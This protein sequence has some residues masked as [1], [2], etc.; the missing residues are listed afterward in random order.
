MTIFFNLLL[1]GNKQ[2]KCCVHA[3][4]KQFK[5]LKFMKIQVLIF[6]FLTSSLF[7]QTYDQLAVQ[8][9]NDMII[10]NELQATPNAPETWNF[11]TW[12]NSN[13]KQIERLSLNHRN[14][15]GEVSFAGLNNLNYLGCEKNNLTKIDV[16]NCTGLKQ[17]WCSGNKLTEINLSNCNSLQ[18]LDCMWNNITELNFSNS[19]GLKE[20]YCLTNKLTHLDLTHLPDLV[21]LICGFNPL[22]SLDITN[23]LYLIWLN[24][25]SI[26]LTTLDVTIFPF[27]E[28]LQCDGNNLTELDISKNPA[29]TS[30]MCYNNKIAELDLSNCTNLIS[31]DC[32][33]NNLTKL[34]LFYCPLL[35]YL[36][37][38]GNH[39]TELNLTELLNLTDYYYADSQIVPI[40]LFLNNGGDYTCNIEL[41]S[42]T[43]G[44]SSINYWN[45]ILKSTNSN[46]VSSTFTVQTGNNGYELSGTMNFNY[47]GAGIFNNRDDQLILNVF[48]NPAKDI[49]FIEYENFG[50][51]TIE[52]YDPL[53]RKVLQQNING[54]SEID[55]SILP[56][57]IYYI[58]VI[59]EGKVIGNNKVVKK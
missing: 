24:C 1:K 16:T 18:L 47:Y 15:T 3:I 17:I 8:R 19:T 53:G 40:T 58:N 10:N 52:L 42:P 36:N 27:L 30:L 6:W 50:Q 38:R 45:G 34:D 9:I 41:N 13:P 14:L 29:L 20:L 25:S 11:A 57:G 56:T 12:N 28:G 43:L 33:Y 37:C 54:K 23:N 59:S 39:L 7:A 5:F 32:D 46:V 48:P 4:N 22:S 2:Y 31:L 26:N 44:N 51:T 49:V 35:E 55:I 21:N